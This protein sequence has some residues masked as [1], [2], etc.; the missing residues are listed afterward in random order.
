MGKYHKY[1]FN[2]ENR[3]FIGDFETMYQN[4]SKE[5]F[6]SWHQDDIRQLQRKID[7]AILQDYNFDKIMDIGCGKGS[8]T[9]LLKKKNNYVLGI[10]ISQ[11][12]IKFAKERYPDID[13]IC[14]DVNKIEN[15][16]SIVSEMGG[17]QFIIPEYPIGF[18][19][20]ET[21]LVKEI[22]KNLK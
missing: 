12:A 9:H 22:E 2:L 6:D 8:L 3:K 1:V 14:T 15:Y 13:F 10:D 19:K 4:E 21:E 5:I 17:G 7:L 16:N 18:V 20:S 11:T